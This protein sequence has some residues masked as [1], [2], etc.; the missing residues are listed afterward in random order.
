[1][2]RENYQRFVQP[3]TSVTTSMNTYSFTLPPS[4]TGLYIAVQDIGSCLTLSRLRVYRNNCKS[5][6]VGLVRYPDAPPPSSSADISVSCVPNS[7]VRDGSGYVTCGS[8]GNWGPETPQCE[9]DDGFQ[10]IEGSCNREYIAKRCFS[11]VSSFQRLSKSG[12]HTWAG[13]M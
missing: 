9:C 7:S 3:S 1:M 8:D 13:S 6:E 2:N 11:E 10:E 5:R 4:S 12:I